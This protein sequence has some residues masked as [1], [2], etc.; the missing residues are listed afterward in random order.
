ML[1][2]NLHPRPK[3]HVVK[4]GNC[5]HAWHFLQMAQI[6]IYHTLHI[7]LYKIARKWQ[8]SGERSGRHEQ[9]VMIYFLLLCGC[10]GCF[11]GVIDVEGKIFAMRLQLLIVRPGPISIRR[12]CTVTW[13]RQFGAT[14]RDKFGLFMSQ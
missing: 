6:S 3:F 1:L 7:A 5:S 14:C 2:V 13:T 8:N 9:I 4:P 12:T 11:P 10:V